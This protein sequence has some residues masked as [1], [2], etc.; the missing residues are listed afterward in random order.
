[1]I[2]SLNSGYLIDGIDDPGKTP[3]NKFESK[4]I[5][6]AISFGT[7]VSQTDLSKIF[8][9]NS[10]RSFPS[11]VFASLPCFF[12]LPIYSLFMLPALTKTLFKALKPKS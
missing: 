1:M 3:C 4:G 8:C 11:I 10:R 6:S 2:L 9:S 12:K 5:S 7:I